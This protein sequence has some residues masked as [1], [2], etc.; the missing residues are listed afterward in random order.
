[1]YGTLVVVLRSNQLI[2]K[3]LKNG[4]TALL[5]VATTNIPLNV[6]THGHYI[7]IN[8]EHVNVH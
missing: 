1:M 6:T 5:T 4:S 7:T 2:T 8:K 3:K